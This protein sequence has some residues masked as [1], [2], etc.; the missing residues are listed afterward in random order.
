MPWDTRAPWSLDHAVEVAKA[1]LAEDVYWM[2]EPL[3][4]GDYAG[5]AALRREVPI[6]LAGGEMTREPYELRELLERGGLDVFQ[7][8]CVCTGGLTGLK[9]VARAVED[10]GCVF[11]PHTWGNGIGLMANLHLCAGTADPPFVEF[12][13]DPPEWTTARR[14]YPL[15]QTIEIDGEGWLELPERSG[16]GIELDEA[17]LA[18]TRADRPTFA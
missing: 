1:L 14:D 16:L 15:T 9:E 10:A 11:T 12:P 5:H 13:F 2:E 8:D 6:R 7:P 3:H 17:R 18:A 4:R